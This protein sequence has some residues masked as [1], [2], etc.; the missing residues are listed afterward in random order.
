MWNSSFPSLPRTVGSSC[1]LSDVGPFRPDPVTNIQLLSV[2][3]TYAKNRESVKVSVSFNW[4]TPEFTGEEIVGYQVWLGKTS[5]SENLTRLITH[6][7]LETSAEVE[8]TFDTQDEDFYVIL[9]VR[10][11]LQ[12][13]STVTSCLPPSRG[14]LCHTQ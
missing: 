1:Q 6:G 7:A 10:L 2:S 11:E 3:K 8:M 13:I 14:H 5:A 4:T 12:L 9:Q